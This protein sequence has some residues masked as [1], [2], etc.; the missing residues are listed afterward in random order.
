MLWLCNEHKRPS[1]APIFLF[2]GFHFCF[3]LEC[4]ALDSGNN[5]LIAK[6]LLQARIVALVAVERGAVTKNKRDWLISLS[7]SSGPEQK[8]FRELLKHCVV[9]CLSYLLL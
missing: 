1:G 8:R 4:A 9:A 6:I 5:S 3:K 7:C 2:Y